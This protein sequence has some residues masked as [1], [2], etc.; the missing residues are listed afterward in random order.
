MAEELRN[1]Q[2]TVKGGTGGQQAR[3]EEKPRALPTGVHAFDTYLLRWIM[4]DVH[5]Y[6]SGP[7]G[8]R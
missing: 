2:I 8:P 4:A 5:V 1:G 6:S 7:K 3:E